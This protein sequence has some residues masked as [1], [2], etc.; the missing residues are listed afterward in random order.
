ML[1]SLLLLYIV[2]Y[3]MV[4]YKIVYYHLKG[5]FYKEQH[6]Y[7]ISSSCNLYMAFVQ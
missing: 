5:G 3:Y 4:Y 1:Y 6:F 2:Y 7:I